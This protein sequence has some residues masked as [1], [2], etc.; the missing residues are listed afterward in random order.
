M[1]HIKKLQG[2]SFALLATVELML[3][4]KKILNVILVKQPDHEPLILT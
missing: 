2:T 1:A 4:K 3:K